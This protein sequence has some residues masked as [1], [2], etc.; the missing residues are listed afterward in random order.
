MWRQY[1]PAQPRTIPEIQAAAAAKGK[2][3][4]NADSDADPEDWEDDN[5]GNDDDDDEEEDSANDT[6]FAD[7]DDEDEGA[8]A[9]ALRATDPN[10]P[11]PTVSELRSRLQQRIADIQAHKRGAAAPKPSADGESAPAQSKEELL[12]DLRA[13]RGLLRDNR[14]KKRKAERRGE[15]AE[16]PKERIPSN[17]RKGGGKANAPEK[18]GEDGWREDR[19][20]NRP[21]KREVDVDERPVKRSKGSPAP[22][23]AVVPASKAVVAAPKPA[24]KPAADA[25]ALTFS[26][27]DFSTSALL[28][29]QAGQAKAGSK[30]KNRHDLPKDANAAL[31]ILAARKAKLEELNPEQREKAEDKARWEKVE[32]KASGEKV[33][34]DEKRLKKMAKRQEKVKSKSAKAWAER[35]ETVATSISSKIKKRNENLAARVKAGKDKKAGIKPTTVR[36]KTKSKSHAGRQKT[37]GGGRAGFEG[38]GKK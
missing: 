32:L 4:A 14:R 22:E 37:G 17:G 12:D 13:R 2:A 7:S 18:V 36:A 28:A 3:K 20:G 21:Q 23:Q 26:T 19:F 8:L 1:D 33:R 35:K 9:L 29:A 15:K 38:K 31:D 16:Q 24:P 27:L 25:S 10:A 30:R 6:D 11:A 34:D 5:N